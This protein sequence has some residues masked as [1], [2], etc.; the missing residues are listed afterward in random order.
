[1]TGVKSLEAEKESMGHHL[2]SNEK[3]TSES[4]TK[5]DTFTLP[6]GVRRFNFLD[7][8]TVQILG[9]RS[10]VYEINQAWVR[11]RSTPFRP[12]QHSLVYKH[13]VQDPRRA[14]E[15]LSGTLYLNPMVDWLEILE[16]WRRGNLR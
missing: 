11:S 3:A 13:R 16:R 1:M 14:H 8:S 12:S 9:S 2:R 7:D 6:C 15:T 4:S 10:F 5:Q